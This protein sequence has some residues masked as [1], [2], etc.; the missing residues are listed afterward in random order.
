MSEIK[1]K[2]IMLESCQACCQLVDIC[3]NCKE[4]FKVNDDIV[5]ISLKTR[6]HH[7]HKNCN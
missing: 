3:F 7:V 6:V 4:I 2:V 1:T 5:C